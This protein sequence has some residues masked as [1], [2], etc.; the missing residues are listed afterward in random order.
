MKRILTI[1]F[2]ALILSL[3]IIH[4]PVWAD[5]SPSLDMPLNTVAGKSFSLAD[6]KG[7]VLV[8]NFWATWCPPCLDE[9]PELIQFQ[10]EFAK[11][12]VQVI[13]I[14]FMEKPNKERLASFIEKHDINYPIVFGK[15]K[16]M[17]NFAKG[18]GGVF[19][20]PVTKFLDRRGNIVSS[21]VGG[22]TAKQLRSYIGPILHGQ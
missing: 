8:I 10:K 13:G 14:D 1:C 19:G 3:T 7:K 15:S 9:I 4:T 18:L 22:I 17:L 21:H 5:R 16:K 11:R 12:G 20:L 6:F 2:A